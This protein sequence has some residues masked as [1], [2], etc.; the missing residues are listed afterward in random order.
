MISRELSVLGPL[1]P[2]L[3]PIWTLRRNDIFK[4]QCYWDHCVGGRHYF[5]VVAKWFLMDHTIS[6]ALKALRE[7]V[8][9]DNENSSMA[10]GS[11]WHAIFLLHSTLMTSRR[12]Q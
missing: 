7:I 12:S 11:H 3:T 5:E 2:W 10:V 1:C 9:T 8:R 4:T 6:L